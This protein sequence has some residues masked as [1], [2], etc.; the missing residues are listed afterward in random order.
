MQKIA[1]PA[2]N[3]ARALKMADAARAHDPPLNDGAMTPDDLARL[4][5]ELKT[6]LTAIAAAAEI[7][8]DERLGPMANVRYRDYARDIHESAAHALAVIGRLLGPGGARGVDDRIE[9]IDLNDLVARTMATV[10]PMASELRLRLSFE[11]GEGRPSVTANATALRQILLNLLS[12]ALKFTPAL[13]EVRVG[14]GQS[15]DGRAFLVVRDTGVGIDEAS[16]RRALSALEAPIDT[17]PG[18]G[19]GIGLPL[20]CR[21]VEDMGA[22]I[23]FD[24][25][26][27]GGTVIA[28]T[29]EASASR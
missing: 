12:N 4:A 21:L 13:G 3:A 5:H 7:M 6:P 18:G 28:V 2:L 25:A 27:G 23:T 8:R 20:V 17:R 1:K 26:P 22:K 19:H 16:A 11:P 9:P 15:S 10:Q 14:A 24:A 29:F